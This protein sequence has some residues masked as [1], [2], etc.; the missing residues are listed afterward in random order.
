VT[1][2]RCAIFSFRVVQT[3]G[4]TVTKVLE[5]DLG[6]GACSIPLVSSVWI[7]VGVLWGGRPGLVRTTEELGVKFLLEDDGELVSVLG[8]VFLSDAVDL[9]L[10]DGDSDVVPLLPALLALSAYERV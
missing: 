2:A 4:C 3:F 7:S 5:G 1:A 9:D 6:T 10:E 8:W